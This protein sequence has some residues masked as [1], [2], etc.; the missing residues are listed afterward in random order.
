MTCIVLIIQIY[1]LGDYQLIGLANIRAKLLILI[2][3]TYY[4]Y[5]YDGRFTIFLFQ[6]LLFY[7]ILFIY[8][9]I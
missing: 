5:T 8:L 2:F 3:K 9:F 7:F 1:P 4:K 6:H